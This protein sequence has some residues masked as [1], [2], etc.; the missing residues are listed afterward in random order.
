M[1]LDGS[2]AAGSK[3]VRT[4]TPQANDKQPRMR[5]PGITSCG[6]SQFERPLLADCARP[7]G[8]SRTDSG[9]SFSRSSKRPLCDL[10]LERRGTLAAMARKSANRREPPT[11]AAINLQNEF[12]ARGWPTSAEVGMA[13][14]SR[15][16]VNSAMWASDTARPAPCWARG[17]LR[18][19]LTAPR[20]PVRPGWP[21][22]IRRQ[23]AAGRT[24]HAPDL[25]PEADKTG[26]HRVFWM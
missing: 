19:A 8:R 4:D 13:N 26:W 10:S 14:G 12:I 11:Q 9:R 17:R 2:R 20:L 23:G 6:P 24:G 1:I 15:T 18:N 22:E 16:A 21:P 7:P 3:A 25:T 5:A